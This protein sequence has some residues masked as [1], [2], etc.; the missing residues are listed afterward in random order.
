MQND[1]HSGRGNQ[2]SLPTK[3]K[4][5]GLRSSCHLRGPSSGGQSIWIFD[6]RSADIAAVSHIVR[7]WTFPAGMSYY[8]PRLLYRPVTQQEPHNQIGEARI[9]IIN[10]CSPILRFRKFNYRYRPPRKL[11]RT[12]GGAV[13]HK[14]CFL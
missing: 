14:S 4:H 11:P 13:V 5:L 2:R 12:C 10:Q 3:L 8:L 9:N 1:L 6:K 7:R